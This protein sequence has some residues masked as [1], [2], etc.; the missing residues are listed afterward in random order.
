M[1]ERKTKLTTMA[2]I[3]KLLGD[4]GWSVSELA[5]RVNTDQRKVDRFVKSKTLPEAVLLGLRISR[6]L[7]VPAEW[8]YDDSQAFPVPP[9]SAVKMSGVQLDKLAEEFEQLAKR[10]REFGPPA[11]P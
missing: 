10:L 11:S 7:E 9:S 3:R 2:K 5:R 4:R 6:A 8:L 1:R